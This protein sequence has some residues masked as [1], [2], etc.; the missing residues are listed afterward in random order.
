MREGKV[1][2]SRQPFD[3]KRHGFQLRPE[4]AMTPRTAGLPPR[5][6]L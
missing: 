3:T 6:G 2:V 5:A 4:S 1:R